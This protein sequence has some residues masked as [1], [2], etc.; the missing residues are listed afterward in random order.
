MTHRRKAV[1]D[2]FASA[3][4]GLGLTGS[5]V[6]KSRLYALAP[7]ELP[8]LRIYTP[9]EEQDAEPMGGYVVPLVRRIRIVCEA[10]TKASSGADDTADA[11]CEQVEA[12]LDAA[13]TLSGAVHRLVLRG[14]EQ[15]MSGDADQPVF[16]HRMVFEAV[17]AK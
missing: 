15:D 17:A 7:D 11:I 1:R 5:R 8:A 4:T 16:V 12:A 3:V 6:Y 2:A 14:Y 10:V 9:S 13:P